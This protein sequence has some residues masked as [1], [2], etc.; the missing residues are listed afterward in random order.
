MR[1]A[2]LVWEHLHCKHHAL[3]YFGTSQ[4]DWELGFIKDLDHAEVL[5]RGK[6]FVFIGR[7]KERIDFARMKTVWARE[8]AGVDIGRIG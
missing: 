2:V 4:I 6:G 7:W 3:V 5:V 8:G 1:L